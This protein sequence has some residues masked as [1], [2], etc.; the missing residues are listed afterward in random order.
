MRRLLFIMSMG[1]GLLGL[2]VAMVAIHN[3]KATLAR[4]ARGIVQPSR[5]QIGKF[6]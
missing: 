4:H 6:G 5:F 3:G 1:A 2:L